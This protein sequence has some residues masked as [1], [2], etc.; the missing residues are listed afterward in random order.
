[1]LSRRQREAA[2]EF[3]LSEAYHDGPAGALLNL[4]PWLIAAVVLIVIAYTPMVRDVLRGTFN[5][6]PGYEPHNPA[7]VNQS[8]QLEETPSP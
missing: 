1:A 3:P 4:R 2:A 7:P 5:N 8:E 6:A